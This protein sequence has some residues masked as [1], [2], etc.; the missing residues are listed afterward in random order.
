MKKYFIC[1]LSLAIISFA[2]CQKT[3]DTFLTFENNIAAMNPSIDNQVTQGTFFAENIAVVSEKENMGGDEQLTSGAILLINV[4]N[5]EVVYADH[6]FDKMYPAGLTKLLTALVVLQYG[7]LSDTVTV[8][9]NATKIADIGAKVCGYK[10]GDILSL[11]S[12]LY[13]LLISSGNDAA[14]AI[15][16]HVGGS[17]EGFVAMMNQEARRVG[18][19]HSNFINSHG[20]H[21]DNQY[22]TAYDIYLICNELLKTDMF[23]TLINTTSYTI[24][25]KDQSGNLQEMTLESTNSKW[26][27][28]DNEELSSKTSIVGGLSGTTKKSGYCQVLLS[29]NDKNE[30]FISIILNASDTQKLDSEI[31]H[32]LSLTF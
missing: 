28:R 4:T 2:G 26:R 5:Q 11:E 12:L 17:E 24:E 14:I 3:S 7:E 32:L 10:E 29:E 18:A 19:V 15:A 13:S 23:K 30:E 20:L 25:Y 22:T 8:S 27:D 31:L 16:E 6:V 21:N 1:L 9:S